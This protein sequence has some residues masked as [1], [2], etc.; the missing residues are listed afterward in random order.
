MFTLQQSN[1]F[2]RSNH[3]SRTRGMSVSLV[4]ATALLLVCSACSESASSS[5]DAG[6][7]PE[8]D[9]SPVATDGETTAN[10]SS[11]P[12]VA[13]PCGPGWDVSEGAAFIEGTFEPNWLPNIPLDGST[14]ALTLFA[15]T[16]TSGADGPELYVALCN[17]GEQ[18]LCGAAIQLE[19][20]D[21]ADQLIGMASSGVHSGRR[22]RFP[23]SEMTISCV[24]PGQTA[25]ASAM[26]LPEGLTLD[27]L[28]SIGHRFPA[29]QID[30]ALPLPGASVSG[31]EAFD[32]AGGTVFRGTVTNDSDAPIS[33]PAVFVFPVNQVGRPL[34]AATSTAMVEIPPGGTWSFETDV[35]P[36]RGVD[37]IA[38]GLATFP[39]ASP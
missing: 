14:G 29:F 6:S 39:T 16:L 17:D 26:S 20:Y 21:H 13:S 22:Y 18:P 3:D 34:G 36:E 1:N 12:G 10:D 24:A 23:D 30:G 9:T 35:V 2:V 7:P 11:N 33:D 38:F 8:L 19:F 5:E 25:M 32:A 31:V 37:T 4:T 27:E 28:K 15:S